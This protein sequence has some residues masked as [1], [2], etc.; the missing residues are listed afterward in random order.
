MSQIALPDLL[1]L[2]RTEADDASDQNLTVDGTVGGKQT[3]TQTRFK[4]ANVPVVPTGFELRKN[5]ALLTLVV[6]APGPAEYNLDATRGIVT[7]GAAAVATDLLQATYYW[8]HFADDTYWRFLTDAMRW[9]GLMWTPTVDDDEQTA[10]DGLV[11]LAEGLIPAVQT[12]SRYLYW[13]RRASD[14]AQKFS[15]STGGVSTNG[16]DDVSNKF[17]QLAKD[18]LT[19]AE[20][21]RLDPYQ[22]FGR[23]EIPTSVQ[24]PIN[25]MGRYSPRR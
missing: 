13:K 1:R 4:L 15:S 8:M 7:L 10:E 21:R 19:E 23:R 17:N 18:A 24:A 16:V 12:Y 14:W 25:G 11:A 9:T 6:P 3:G 2:I 20:A 22:G 5:G